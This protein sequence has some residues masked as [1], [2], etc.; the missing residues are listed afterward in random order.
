MLWLQCLLVVVCAMSGS[1]K[2]DSI[3]L[4]VC[5]SSSMLWQSCQLYT[6]V[7]LPLTC[8]DRWAVWLAS[9]CALLSLSL[10]L[11][12]SLFL[13]HYLSLILSLFV[14]LCNTHITALVESCETVVILTVILD[15]RVKLH[16][17][18]LYFSKGKRISYGML[19]ECL[20]H[21]NEVNSVNTVLDYPP[22]WS[23]YNPK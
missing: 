8:T 18:M 1:T 15:V 14:S 20:E 4:C 12:L 3:S 22:E 11:L 16:T 5:R 17:S 23:M 7:S 13:S 6:S 19:P 10:S 9:Q 2:C 21:C